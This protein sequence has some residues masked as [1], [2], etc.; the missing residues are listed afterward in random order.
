[1]Q[2]AT[3]KIALGTAQ[4]GMDYGVN[5]QRGQVPVSEIEDMLNYAS[6]Q[7]ISYLHTSYAYGNSETIL[8]HKCG[9][10]LFV[11]GLYL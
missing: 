9:V 5:N 4:F 1:M 2:S 6:S 8:G 10:L 7:D 11:G 3:S